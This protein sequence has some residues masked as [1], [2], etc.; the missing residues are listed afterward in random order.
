V[1][2]IIETEIRKLAILR[3]IDQ[4]YIIKSSNSNL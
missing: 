3:V 2:P 4:L 1:L